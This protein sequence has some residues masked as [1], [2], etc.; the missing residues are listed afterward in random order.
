VKDE[1]TLSSRYNNDEDTYVQ[2]YEIYY[3][4]GLGTNIEIVYEILLLRQQ[5]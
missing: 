4:G 2:E 3:V 5:L 1:R